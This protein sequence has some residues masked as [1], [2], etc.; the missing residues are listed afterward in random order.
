MTLIDVRYEQNGSN[1]TDT[2]HRVTLFFQFFSVPNVC[3]L[4]Y[5]I[6]YNIFAFNSWS[7]RLFK[8]VITKRVSMV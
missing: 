2:I 4:K 8:S 5:L 3:E 6:G 1:A 7:V